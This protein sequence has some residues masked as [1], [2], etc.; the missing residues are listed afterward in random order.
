M[1]L[2]E[3]HQRRTDQRVFAFIKAT[4][5]QGQHDSLDV[6]KEERTLISLLQMERI[7]IIIS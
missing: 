7:P 3:P 5:E 2:N 6:L 1:Q 4:A